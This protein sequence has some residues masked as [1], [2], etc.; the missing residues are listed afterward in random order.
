MNEFVE[1]AA[2]L[3]APLYISYPRVGLLSVAGGDLR[4]ILRKHYKVVSLVA[5]VPLNH[6]TMG[7]APGK[8]SVRALEDVYYAGWN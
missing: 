2:A 8:A 7:G 6:S 1:A 4:S 3:D 5:H